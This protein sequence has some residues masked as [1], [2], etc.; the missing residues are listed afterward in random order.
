[1]SIKNQLEQDKRQALRAGDK[2]KR[3]VLTLLVAAIQQVEVDEQ[4]DLDDTAVQQVLLKQAKQRRESI[5]DYESA[6]RPES[7]AA[8]KYELEIIES[9]LPRMLGRE[10]I[11]TEA[12]AVIA[13]VGAT[14]MKQMGQVMGALMPKLQGQADGRLVSSVVRELLQNR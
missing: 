8:E 5:A 4:V 1:M 12:R 2:E 10:E 9:Y 7:A 3:R 11:E 14:D 13:S 6:G